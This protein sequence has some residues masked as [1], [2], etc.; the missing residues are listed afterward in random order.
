MGKLN[1]KER[2]QALNEVRI[3]A[4]LNH[5]NI[6]GYRDAFYVEESNNLNIVME[7]ASKGDLSK[8]IEKH[9]R[10]QTRIQ[11]EEIWRVLAH[12]C[13]GLKYLHSKNIIHRDLKNANVFIKEDGTYL[14][15]DLNIS[16]VSKDGMA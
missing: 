6:I 13:R 16:K 8:V 2:N 10:D 15:G 5:P 14:I 12:V 1:A 4:S 11:E 7:Y 9:K 3:L